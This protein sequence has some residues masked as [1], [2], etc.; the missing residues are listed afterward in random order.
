MSASPTPAAPQTIKGIDEYTDEKQVIYTDSAGKMQITNI[1]IEETLREIL[2]EIRLMR[3]H[4]EILTGE[5]ID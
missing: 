1:S 4:F 3:Q 5:I 2:N